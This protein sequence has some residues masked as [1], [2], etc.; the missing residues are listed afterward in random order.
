M[1]RTTS[2]LQQA[3]VIVEIIQRIPRYRWITTKEL[4]QSL[5]DAD[6]EIE[7]LTLQRTLKQLYESGTLP[8]ERND[9]S[10]PYGYRM[11]SES[12]PLSF[13]KLSPHE[14]LCMRLMEENLKYQMPTRVVKSMEPLFEGARQ[15]LHKDKQ[16]SSKDSRWLSKVAVVSDTLPRIPPAIKPRI[17][18]S[19]SDAL[20]E[21]KQLKISY[22]NVEGKVSQA[23]VHPLGLVQQDCRLYLVCRFDGYDNIRHIS[24]SRMNEAIKLEMPLIETNDFKLS[25]YIKKRHF[26]YSGDQIHL[27]CLTVDFKAEWFFRHLDEV[28]LSA[29]QK[30][31]QLG[32]EHYRLEVNLPDSILLEHWLAMYKEDAKIV[33]V[34]KSLLEN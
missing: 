18:E 30:L 20:Y 2:G 34:Q 33:S 23:V 28:K 14:A 6:I 4:L 19:V 21:E 24:L 11:R 31:C 13:M 26:N 7:E 10:K 25:D 12:S 29:D 32:N 5:H 3:L 9:L 17:F 16:K 15:S 27:I 8:I 22:R 1:A